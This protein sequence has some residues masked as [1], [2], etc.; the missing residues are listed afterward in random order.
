MIEQEYKKTITKA[1]IAKKIN[2]EIGLSE[3]S[4]NAIIEHILNEINNCLIKDGTVKISSFGTFL[5][6]DKSERPGNVPNTSQKVVVK[7]RKSI[8]FK[9]SKILKKSINNA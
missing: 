1:T 9:P 4:S 8:S 7:A 3:E 5:V 6:V 2:Q